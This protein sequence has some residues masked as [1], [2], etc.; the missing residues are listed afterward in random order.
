MKLWLIMMRICC[1]VSFDLWPHFLG[2]PTYG[3][4]RSHFPLLFMGMFRDHI[5]SQRFHRLASLPGRC[6]DDFGF[7]SSS[8]AARYPKPGLDWSDPARFVAS[9]KQMHL[10]SLKRWS[11]ETKGN[12]NQSGRFCSWYGGLFSRP[13][14][15]DGGFYFLSKLEWFKQ[16]FLHVISCFLPQ[17]KTR[18]LG[19]WVVCW[20]CTKARPDVL[21]STNTQSHNLSPFIFLY[22][23]Y[24][25]KLLIWLLDHLTMTL[26]Y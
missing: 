19:L 24:F 10:L 20:W 18:R 26:I 7:P 3:L 25:F 16:T 13:R 1:R 5:A 8:S 12:S 14:T 11:P 4:C 22:H 21:D 9:V 2:F 6:C 15:S 23:Y 17:K